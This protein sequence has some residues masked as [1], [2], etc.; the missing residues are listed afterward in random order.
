MR[1]ELLV[2]A[3]KDATAGK[4][5]ELMTNIPKINGREYYSYIFHPE[6]DFNNFNSIRV[7]S[8]T[9]SYDEE[10]VILFR[11]D[12]YSKSKIVI[13]FENIVQIVTDEWKEDRYEHLDD[14]EC[15]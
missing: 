15:Y 8:M 9:I 12:P 4:T 13:G 5:V 3:L 6:Y 11:E 10:S 7:D 2:E 14:Y 1:K